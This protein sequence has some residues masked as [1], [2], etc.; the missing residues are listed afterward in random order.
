MMPPEP[1]RI[2]VVAAATVA[3]MTGGAELATLGMLW[4]SAS[5]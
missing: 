1:T 3:I 5:Q 2:V 4:C